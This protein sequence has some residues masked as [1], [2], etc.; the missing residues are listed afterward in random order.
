MEEANWMTDPSRVS[1]GF[2]FGMRLH[3]E[4]GE[5]LCDLCAGA[6]KRYAPM[7]VTPA[8]AAAHR[9][10]LEDAVYVRQPYSGRANRGGYSIQVL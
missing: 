7:P 9:K 6:V 1:C 8:E 4:K 3:Q 5:I 2:Y 10:A